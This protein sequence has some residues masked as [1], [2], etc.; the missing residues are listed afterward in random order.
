MADKVPGDTKEDMNGSKFSGENMD[1]HNY[2][3]SQAE[4]VVDPGLNHRNI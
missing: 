1:S 3:V 4:G 2:E